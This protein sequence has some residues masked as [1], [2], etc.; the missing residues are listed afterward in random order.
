[1]R[2]VS[3][4]LAGA[5]CSCAPSTAPPA[6]NLSEYCAIATRG[7][8]HAW[9][10][11]VVTACDEI[12]AAGDHHAPSACSIF[13]A[14]G[15][16]L[17]PIAIE[18]ARLAMPAYDGR[19]VV[20]T[21]DDR[22]LFGMPDALH[23]IARW[24]AEPRVSDDGRLVAYV[25]LADGIEAPE[26]GAPTVIVL[27]DLETDRTEIVSNDALASSPMPIPG[28]REVL[29]VSTSSGVA[30]LWRAGTQLTNAGMERVE[31]GFVPIPHRELA[32][33]GSNELVFTAEDRVWRVNLATGAGEALGPG[34][35]PRASADGSIVARRDRSADCSVV[36]LEGRTP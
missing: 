9:I 33:I 18:G 8:L 24:A 25:A 34:A 32:W 6:Q 35:W 10:G 2:H 5:L 27:H 20:L 4:L 36:Y 31:Q 12:P 23:E 7:D 28:T 15:S 22:L 11:D 14:R 30:S 1:L 21:T 29:Y 26:L 19:L 13:R 17:S 16:E 3:L